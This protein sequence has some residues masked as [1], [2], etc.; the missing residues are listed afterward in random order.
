MT[1]SRPIAHSD[2]L[3]F[4]GATG[5]LAHKKVFPG[6]AGDGEARPPERA[7]HRRGQGELE[8][9]TIASAR[10]REPRD[11]RRRRRRCRIRQALVAPALR[12]RRLPRSSDVRSAA[13]RAGCGRA[14]A[15]LPRHSAEL[16][17]DRGR[18]ARALRLRERRTRRRGEAVRPRPRLRARRSTARSWRCSP[19][20]PSSA[21]ITTSARSRCRTCSTSASATRS[22]SRCGTA[23]TSPAC[24][25]PWPRAS[26]SRA[27]AASTTRPAPSAT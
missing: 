25:S 16:V 27:A 20:R 5:D 9:R 8:P 2:A 3:V 17:L 14:A 6:A 23:T 24:R 10:T 15:A 22:S 19:S 26:G 12:G 11:T 18:R 13:P 21:S 1:E 4:F 7:G